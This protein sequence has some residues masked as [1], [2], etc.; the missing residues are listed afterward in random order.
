MLSHIRKYPMAFFIFLTFAY[1]LVTVVQWQSGHLC[2]WTN[3][4]WLD[5]DRAGSR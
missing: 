4:G 5:H 1:Q 2:L 3:P